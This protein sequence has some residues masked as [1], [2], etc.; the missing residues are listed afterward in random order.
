MTPQ[1]ERLTVLCK[2]LNLLHLPTQIA[3]LGQMAAKRELGYLDFLEQALKDEA[4]ARAERMRRML[5]RLAGFPAI[6]TL[7]EFD[8][9]FA[10]GVPKALVL[11]LGSLA[12]VERA[13]NVVLLGPSGVGKTHLAVALGYRA[14]QAGFRTRF[15][16][17]ADLLMQLTTALRR[18]Q[19][20]ETIKRITKP[21]RLL[22]IDEMGYLPMDREQANLL[23]QVVAKRY[24]TGSLILTSNLPFGQWDQTFADDATLTAALLDRLLHHAHVVPISGDSYRLKEKRQAGMINRI[25]PPHLNDADDVK[26]K[27][28]SKEAALS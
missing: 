6:K 5:T 3:H 20:E 16:T 23:F 25:P 19:L 2:Q 24:E 7:D 12:F 8:F 11:E 10:L 21:Y 28:N 26:R 15:I 27:R 9:E 1:L 22:I 4:M 17:A 13:E 14:T 18:N